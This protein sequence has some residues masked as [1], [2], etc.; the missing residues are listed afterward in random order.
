LPDGFHWAVP[1]YADIV[2]EVH[3]RPDGR[4]HALQPSVDVELSPNG[5]SRA[6][7]TLV[8]MVRK[9][10]V[11]IGA[12]QTVEDALVLEHD[13]DLVALTPRANGVCTALSIQAHLPDASVIDIV[14][15]DD[16]DPH[17]R[18]PLLLTSPLRL[19]KGT[20][21][22]SRW[23]LANTEANPRNP[24]VPLDRY[25]AAMR[26]GVVSWLLHVAAADA[27]DDRQLDPWVRGQ[28]LKR[29]K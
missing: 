8:S 13:V 15:L 4:E 28:L 17:W 7:R 22:E 10:D 25:T 2:A 24:F 11:E 29:Q 14:T 27:Q 26:T 20:R 3:F 1:A 19:P 23:T 18:R 12:T 6:L 9:V 16:W 21:L 5:P